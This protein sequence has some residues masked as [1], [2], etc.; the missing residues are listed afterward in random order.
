MPY[1]NIRSEIL[2]LLVDV[3]VFIDDTTSDSKVSD[4]VDVDLENW[5]N[6][7]LVSIKMEDTLPPLSSLESVDG[8]GGD[9]HTIAPFLLIAEEARST[10]TPARPRR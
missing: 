4:N 7:S 9:A 8:S 5:F 1:R 10:R 3:L 2:R 6:E